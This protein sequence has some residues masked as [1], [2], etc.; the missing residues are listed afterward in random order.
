VKFVPNQPIATAEPRVLVD[1]GLPAG[2]H[3]FRLEVENERGQRS[4][5]TEVTVL[6]E[7]GDVIRS[8][9]PP[10]RRRS[11]RSIAPSHPPST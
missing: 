5:P 1:A 3:R 2:R 11:G 7:N 8:V 9:T 10:G 6:I 4:L